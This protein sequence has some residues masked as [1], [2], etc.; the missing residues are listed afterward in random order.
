[1]QFF[2]TFRTGMRRQAFM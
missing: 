1:M 2:D